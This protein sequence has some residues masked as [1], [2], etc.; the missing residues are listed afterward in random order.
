MGWTTLDSQ[1]FL[2]TPILWTPMDDYG[3]LW[4]HLDFKGLL[5][6]PMDAYGLLWTPTDS[7]GLLYTPTGHSDEIGRDMKHEGGQ[8]KLGFG[9]PKQKGAEVGNH[10]FWKYEGA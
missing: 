4:T 9:P 10:Q 3:P 6:T 8:R 7:Y 2:R 1:G 5:R